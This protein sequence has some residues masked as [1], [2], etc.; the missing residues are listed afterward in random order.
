MS[1]CMIHNPKMSARAPKTAA[2]QGLFA[3]DYVSKGRTGWQ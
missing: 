2:K 1:A 3:V